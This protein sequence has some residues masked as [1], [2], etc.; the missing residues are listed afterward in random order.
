MLFSPSLP[1][2]RTKSTA[3]IASKRSFLVIDLEPKLKVV[4]D[5]KSGK[6]VMVIARQ[7]GM[8]HSSI[9]TILKNKNKVT[10]PI[11]GPASLK[12]TRRTKIR[13]GPI[14]DMVKL[15]MSWIEY[16]T[17]KRIPTSTMTITTKANNFFR[18]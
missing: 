14:S 18:C 10:G 17:Q 12:A 1:P 16:Q 7:S 9:A 13:E 3:N 15:L 4:K 5:Y 6:S 8:S 2:K 11:K